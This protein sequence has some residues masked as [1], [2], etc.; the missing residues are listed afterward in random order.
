MNRVGCTSPCSIAA[1]V[2]WGPQR[3]Y[4]C[5]TAR[6]AY[7]ICLPPWSSL[8]YAPHLIALYWSSSTNENHASRQNF[9]C[10]PTTTAGRGRGG[11]MSAC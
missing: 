9:C 1:S 6:Q 8:W 2:S 5:G 11:C 4:Y 3:F 10:E 7:Q